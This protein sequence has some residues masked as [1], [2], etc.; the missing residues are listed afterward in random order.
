MEA[1]CAERAPARRPGGQSRVY[2][3]SQ[4]TNDIKNALEDRFGV[5]IVQGE[6]TSLRHASSGHS[7]F[8]L[9]DAQSQISV[10]L[11]A[12][13][14]TTAIRNTIQEGIALQ[15]EGDITVFA[16]R[17]E[18]QIRALRIEPVGYGALQAQFEALKR[19]LEA[20]GLFAPERK[21]DLPRYPTRIGIV[22]FVSFRAGSF[23]RPRR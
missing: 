12:D 8:C 9:K 2:T 21:R 23:C 17:G 13:R 6:V 14:T 15:V 3:V 5:V 19:K 11:Y 7:Y 18:Y 22:R 10:V 16:K 20:E 4:L 1:G